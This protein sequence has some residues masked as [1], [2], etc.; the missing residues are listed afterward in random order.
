MQEEKENDEDNFNS[1]ADVPQQNDEPKEVF[2][3]TEKAL[4]QLAEK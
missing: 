1:S 4:F 3:I 2:D